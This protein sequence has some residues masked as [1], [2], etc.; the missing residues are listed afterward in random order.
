MTELVVALDSP[1]DNMRLL[2]QCAGEGVSWFK[3]G[4]QNIAY[5]TLVAS[6][7]AEARRNALKIFLDL[8]LYDTEATTREAVRRWSA[9]EGI[10]AISVLDIAP[11]LTRAA[12][13]AA[14]AT[15]LKVWSLLE[16][17]DE[18]ATKASDDLF[19]WEIFARRNLRTDGLI[20]PARY[21]SGI[22]ERAGTKDIVAV[23]VRDTE[24]ECSAG[25]HTFARLPGPG[26]THAVVGRPIYNARSTK[27]AVRR[28]IELLRGVQR[29]TAPTPAPAASAPPRP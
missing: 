8:K 25:G 14:R 10:A 21:T 20:C 11:R 7:L 3:L 15:E 22:T 23:G 2:A 4:I 28:Y 27:L 19:R 13:E 26:A 12:I 17:S 6:V 1:N 29:D 16:L 9:I 5:G 18:P 24:T